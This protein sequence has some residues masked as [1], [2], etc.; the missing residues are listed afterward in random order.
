M[1]L[2][3]GELKFEGRGVYLNGVFGLDKRVRIYVGQTTSVRQR[4]SQH[5]NFRYRRDNPSLHYL[6]MQQSIYNSIG[7]L[8]LL[9]SLSP[10]SNNL[11]GMDRPDLLLN[12]L[13]MWMCL[14]FRSLPAQTLE[15]WLSGVEEPGKA[16]KE[17]REGDFGGLNIASPLDQGDKVRDWIDLSNSDDPLILDYIGKRSRPRELEERRNNSTEIASKFPK[18]E[19]EVL[20]VPHWAILGGLAA[21][22]AFVLFNNRSGSHLKL[23]G[24]IR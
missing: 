9:P 6:A 1:K 14:V 2:I 10:S 3:G 5:L 7:L 13:E 8:A 19:E 15:L 23:K 12:V 18:S 21:V 11:P 17:S 24:H 4:V 22:L 20:P 16:E